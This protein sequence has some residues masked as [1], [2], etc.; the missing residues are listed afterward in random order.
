MGLRC[1]YRGISQLMKNLGILWYKLVSSEFMQRCVTLFTG[2]P[3]SK[4]CGAVGFRNPYCLQYKQA[5]KS[6]LE[7]VF[8]QKEAKDFFQV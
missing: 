5:S 1:C 4:F 8:I 3:V 2:E 6:P 7:A